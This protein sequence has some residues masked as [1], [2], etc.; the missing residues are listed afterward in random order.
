MTTIVFVAQASG[1]EA[2]GYQAKFPDLPDSSHQV[3]SSL[4]LS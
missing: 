3:R 4:P 1:D 2:S